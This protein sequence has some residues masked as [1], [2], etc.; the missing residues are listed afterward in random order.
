MAYEIFAEDSLTSSAASIDLTAIPQTSTHLELVINARSTKAS[1]TTNGGEMTFNGSTSSLYG[2]NG[3]Y[4]LGSTSPGI[5]NLNPNS[6]NQ[7]DIPFRIMN[8]SMTANLY[9]QTKMII[10]NYT[11][12]SITRKGVLI[13]TGTGGDSTTVYWTLISMASWTSSAAINQITMFAESGSSPF[14]A[15]TSYYLAGWE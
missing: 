4:L 12:T 11:N 15:G 7:I 8:D 9:A 10:P 3:V 5:Y 14:K 2:H 6:R 1:T 13:Q